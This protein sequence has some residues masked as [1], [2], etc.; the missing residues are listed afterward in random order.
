MKFL[1]MTLTLILASPAWSVCGQINNMNFP[2]SKVTK[3]AVE[4]IDSGKGLAKSFM[5]DPIMASS[6]FAAQSSGSDVCIVKKNERYFVRVDFKD[7]DK[8][9]PDE[10][11]PR[12]NPSNQSI[13]LPI[14]Y[15]LTN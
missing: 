9:K 8:I 4:I 11:N 12:L 13:P 10:E 1:M 15:P 2:V 5:L 3:V 14:R 7:E 6:L